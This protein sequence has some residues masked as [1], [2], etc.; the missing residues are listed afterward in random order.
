M[1]GLLLRKVQGE[2]IVTDFAQVLL[3][4]AVIELPTKSL[5]SEEAAS[6]QTHNG[7]SDGAEAAM[8][9]RPYAVLSYYTISE[10]PG[11]LAIVRYT[12][13]GEKAENTGVAEEKFFDT[14]D[15]FC[16]VQDSVEDALLT[17]VDVCVMSDRPP[18][19]FEHIFKFLNEGTEL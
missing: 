1:N 13:R 18:E 4:I 7:N 15:D 5:Q 12:A 16:R 11:T 10:I 8:D 14:P 6:R 9:E 2:K 3:R 17:G 19:T